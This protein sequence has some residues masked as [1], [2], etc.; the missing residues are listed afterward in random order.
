MERNFTPFPEQ[1]AIHHDCTLYL[2]HLFLKEAA[3]PKSE[4]T[5]LIP[6]R[7]SVYVFSHSYAACILPLMVTPAEVT[8]VAYEWIG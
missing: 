7:H 4:K 2:I 8:C 6:Q 3:M 5:C 1:C